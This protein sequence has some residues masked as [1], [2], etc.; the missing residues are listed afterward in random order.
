MT[1]AA[2]EEADHCAYLSTMNSN[3]LL[4]TGYYIEYDVDSLTKLGLST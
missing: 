1:D 4:P 2:G 3:R